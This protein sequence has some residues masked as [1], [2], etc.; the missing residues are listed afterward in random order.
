MFSACPMS[1]KPFH[2][3]TTTGQCRF[4]AHLFQ[5]DGS[6]CTPFR[7][8]RRSPQA[9]RSPA[10]FPGPLGRLATLSHSAHLAQSRA[11]RNGGVD[12]GSHAHGRTDGGNQGARDHPSTT[13]A[14]ALILAGA[15]G[16][17]CSENSGFATYCHDPRS[18]CYLCHHL[19]ICSPHCGVNAD[20]SG[21]L[22]PLPHDVLEGLALSL[23]AISLSPRVFPHFFRW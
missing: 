13:G 14:L 9:P 21:F 7:A 8:E 1:R 5:S 12:D 16:P 23:M 15:L 11:D 20:S 2:H 10:T 4:L 18:S 3:Q 22:F 6:L 17:Q 19:W